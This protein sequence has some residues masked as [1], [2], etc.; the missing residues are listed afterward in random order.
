MRLQYSDCVIKLPYSVFLHLGITRKSRYVVLQGFS[1]HPF[2]ASV[3]EYRV[4]YS[5]SPSHSSREFQQAYSYARRASC[6]PISA[7]PISRLLA[8][9]VARVSSAFQARP[10]LPSGS[11][12]P[13]TETSPTVSRPG[14]G[15]CFRDRDCC[16][17]K[18]DIRE[19]RGDISGSI[20]VGF[21]RRRLWRPTSS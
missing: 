6:E 3:V 17:N 18:I 20:D 2:K 1:F 21:A 14:S 15:I 13:L 4:L 19:R 8:L 12:R 11:D 5:V 16:P 7:V 9:P 10:V